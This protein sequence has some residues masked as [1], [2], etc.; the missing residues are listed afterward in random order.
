MNIHGSW[1]FGW[2]LW[3]GVGQ[4]WRAAGIVHQTR[5]ANR[6]PLVGSYRLAR[7]IYVCENRLISRGETRSR[8]CRW[9][10][11]GGT[12]NKRRNWLDSYSAEFHLLWRTR[13]KAPSNFGN[14]DSFDG[15]MSLWYT[16]S[17]L[18]SNL[19]YVLTS[20]VMP[21]LKLQPTE[22]YFGDSGTDERLIVFTWYR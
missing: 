13:S 14:H 1:E 2:V 22:V 4:K 19:V 21:T 9:S 15:A 3:A 5:D 20:P 6:R 18:C 8:G 17:I 16:S 7:Y 10:G 12:R 11:Y